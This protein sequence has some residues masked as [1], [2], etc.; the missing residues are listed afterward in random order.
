[1]TIIVDTREERSGNITSLKRRRCD[2][3]VE[4]LEVGD[5]IVGDVVIERK[6]GADF[7]QSIRDKRIWNQ[8]KNLS[9]A[10]YPIIVII[11]ENIWKSMYFSNSNWIHKGFFG[12]LTKLTTSFGITVLMFQSDDDFL[13]YLKTLDAQQNK[14]G[15]G[16][17]P[18][19][20]TRKAVTFDIRQEDCLSTA[21]G[22]SVKTSKKILKHFGSVRKVANASIEQLCKI[23]GISIKKSQEI[24]KLFNEIYKE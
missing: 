21:K 5:Y 8:A 16:V 10:K 22:I 19:E 6:E 20:L 17:R 12:A 11:D 7:I 15:T 3:K 13:R 23:E 18:Q 9:Q 4:Q 24:Y 1:M 14:E 2:V